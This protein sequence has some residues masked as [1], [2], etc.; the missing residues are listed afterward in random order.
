MGSPSPPGAPSRRLS[1]TAA[2][3]AVARRFVRSALSGVPPDMVDTAELLV[4][5]LVTNAVIHA[6][7]EIETRVWVTEGRVHV[8]VSDLRPDRGLVPHD[9][10]P[11]ACTGRGLALVEELSTSHGAHSG[12]DRKTVWFE[13]WPGAPA[14]PTSAWET[15]APSDDTVSVALSDVPYAL[16]WAAQQQWEGLLREL[17]LALPGGVGAVAN[18][19][20]RVAARVGAEGGPEEG[21]GA[22]ACAAALR[23]G[24]ET[25]GGHEPDW[26]G[27]ESDWAGPEPDWAGPEPDWAG[28]PLEDLVVAQDMS[29]VICASMTAAVEQETP[30]SSTLSLLVA[31]PKHAVTA[32]RTLRRVLDE[33]DAAAQ[34]G[35]L[36]VLPSLPQIRAFRHWLLD[37]IAE[38]LE[39]GRPTA[40]TLVRG[41]PS[42]TPTDLAPWDASEV[43]AS[44]VPTIAADDR[45]RIIGVNS[46]AASLLGW[47]AHDLV[48]KRLTVLMPEHLRGR[49]TAAFTSLL[50]TGVPRIL[51]RSIPVPA[52]HRDGRVVPVRLRIETQESI[53]GRTVFV[54]QLTARTAPSAPSR[55]PSDRRHTTRPAPGPVHLPTTRKKS[56]KANFDRSAPEWL[57]V[58]AET[59]RAMASAHDVEVVLRRVCHV[60]TH[61]LADWCAADLFDEA[62][63]LKRVCVV[64]R[65]PRVQVSGDHLGMLP[66][67][68]EATQG[69]L[70][71]V[72]RGAGPLLLTLTPPRGQA[73]SPLEARQLEL[74]EELGGR[75]AVVAPLR[76]HREIL[77]A[78]TLV[79]VRDEHPF[80]KDDVPQIGDLVRS[81]A[82]GVDSARLHRHIRSTA[83]ELQRALLPELPRTGRLEMAARYVPSSTTAEVGGDWYDAFTLPGGDTAL[84]IGDVSGHDL[85]AAVAMSAL[86]NMLRGLAVD[87]E[88]PPG[89][90][91]RRLDLA[92][93]TLDP[94]ATAT[95][96]YAL[97]KGQE[98]GPWDLYH[99]S[100]GHLPPL[101]ATQDGETRYLDAGRGMLIG[102]DPGLPRHS[103][104]DALPPHSTLLLFTDGLIERRGESLDDAMARLSRHAAAHARA[105]LDVFCDELIIKFGADN[106]DDIALLALRPT[107]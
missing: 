61:G 96:V 65:D 53:D 7:T 101:L 35:S 54:A 3:V 106:T 30:D 102:M 5:E 98:G 71:R 40:W 92:T 1:P 43:E 14:P 10:H 48:G 8:R 104:C 38:Q 6:R 75:S 46:S 60:L 97:I 68:S 32:V 103:A 15:V 33:A 52:L 42:D 55:D 26:A 64:H 89:D 44:N 107:P 62:G 37:Q 93:H 81:I 19:V 77:G 18:G 59:G 88:E 67:V 36:L 58:F 23:G 22:G 63:H 41:A 24:A 70:P 47:D 45:N 100:A 94:H 82:L 9:R 13:L 91:L 31:F 76:A 57:P 16:Y 90:V 72:L 12:E 4:G 99:S 17:L 69:S 25:G 84:V 74:V 39:G 51:G 83:E 20:E 87:G 80:T 73:Q 95:C 29:N 2:N 11:Y 85:R 34:Q 27:A 50:L 56:R 86:R 49:H 78:L 79:R 21:L 28:V 105:P 66:P